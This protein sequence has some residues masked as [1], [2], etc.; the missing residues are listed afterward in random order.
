VL[1]APLRPRARR[2]VSFGPSGYHVLRGA[3]PGSFAAV[4]CG[5]LRD[6]FSQIDMLHVDVFW[7]GHNVLVDAGS[8][9]Y[10]GPQRWHELFG[11]TSSHN[12]V[13]LDGR[14][15]MLHYRRFKNIYGI[16]AELLAFEDRPAY[17]LVE[18][19]HHGYARHPGGCVHRR[20]VLFVKD[21]LWI[22]ADR[23]V[24]EGTHAARLHWLGGDFPHRY[25][26][27]AGALALATPAGPFT[28]TVLDEAGAPLAG[29]VV[30]GAQDPPRGW[31][32]RYYGEKVPVPSL[33]VE[34]VAP[35]PITLISV[36]APGR[37]EVRV[38][39]GRYHVAC[40]A[41]RVRFQLD[42]GRISAVEVD[43]APAAE[44]TVAAP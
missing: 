10:N 26:P 16:R 40:G 21:D 34:R 19:E 8:Y 22:V 4:R 44:A 18:G 28:I 32:S 6:R 38:E 42:D 11:G 30:A 14:D 20:A 9:L 43:A 29:D 23:I 25:D 13:G 36:L 41:S 12:T 37:P 1:D 39:A 24:G 35:L 27:A 15:Q 33:A 7:R 5:P 17:A 2:S 3:D 31:T